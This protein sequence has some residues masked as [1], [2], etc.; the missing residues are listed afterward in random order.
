M[1]APTRGE[2]SDRPAH[3]MRAVSSNTSIEASHG[4]QPQAVP[5]ENSIAEAGTPAGDRLSPRF[6]SRNPRSKGSDTTVGAY[7]EGGKVDDATADSDTNEET[8]QWDSLLSD[9]QL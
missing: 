1:T 6:Y 8:L 3:H 7:T 9:E 2:V 5:V 4:L